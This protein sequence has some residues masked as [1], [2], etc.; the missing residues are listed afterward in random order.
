MKIIYVALLCGLAAYGS[1]SLTGSGST[2]VAPIASEWCRDY[3]N[4]HPGVQISYRAVGS[5]EGIRQAIEGTVDFGATDGPMT[6]VEMES[7]KAQH[8]AEVVHFP[9][10]IGA[11][12]PAYNLPGTPVTLNF[13]PDALAG[14]F[15]GTISKWND[16]YLAKAN[17]GIP[18]PDA[19]IVVVHRSD[20]S[21]TSY[22]WADYLAKVNLQWKLTVGVGTSVIWPSGRGG[23][24]NEGVAEAISKTPFSV[25]YLELG[26]AIRNHIVYGNVRNASG[27]FIK[28]D[29]ASVTAAATETKVM[30]EDFRVSIT[31]APG[32]SSYPI[33]SFSWFLVPEEVPNSAK[34]AALIEFIRWVIT[35]GQTEAKGALY[36]PLPPRIREMELKALAKI[37]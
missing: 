13:T 10:V 31:N 6:K 11:V 7:Y 33:S 22:V 36:A 23:K 30:P 1:V 8:H 15:L 9:A 26:Y 4:I 29:L 5:G 19:R 18:L 21:G 2:F 28:A 35:Q 17:P 37:H 24:G 12:A 3:Q 16:P 34:G 25:G 14:I 20:A 27:K 32:D